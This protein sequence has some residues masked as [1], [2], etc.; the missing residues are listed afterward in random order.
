[1]RPGE[2]KSCGAAI[3]WVRTVGGAMMPLDSP[4]PG[5]NVVL[6]G[7]LA[8]VLGGGLFEERGDGPFYTDHNATC[9]GAGGNRKAK[10]R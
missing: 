10:G 8:A 7:G 5:G 6:R 4:S 3:N 1:M 9:P 2:C